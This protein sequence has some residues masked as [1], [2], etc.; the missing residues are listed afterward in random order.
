MSGWD[1]YEHVSTSFSEPVK[2]IIAGLCTGFT[3]YDLNHLNHRI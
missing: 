3:I 2:N 1:V